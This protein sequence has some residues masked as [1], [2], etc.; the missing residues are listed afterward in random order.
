MSEWKDWPIVEIKAEKNS[1][2]HGALQWLLGH[3][4]V[5]PPDY[6]ASNAQTD[7]DV[8]RGLL[9]FYQ[10]RLATARKMRDH[11]YHIRSC[12]IDVCQALDRVWAAQQRVARE[13][14]GVRRIPINTNGT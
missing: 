10:G 7:L 11:K 1:V 8:E 9:R 6:F 12:E 5:P 4:P 3:A 14:A 2:S 13:R